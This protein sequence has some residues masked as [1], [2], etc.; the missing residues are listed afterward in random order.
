MWK[1]PSSEEA[2]PMTVSE[3]LPIV[4][5]ASLIADPLFVILYATYAELSTGLGAFAPTASPEN[6]GSEILV[7]VI[8]A[9]AEVASPQLNA[10]ARRY[11][12]KRRT[13]CFDIWS[14]RIRRI[15]TISWVMFGST[16]RQSFFKSYRAPLH[17][18]RW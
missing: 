13:N 7:M 15:Q 5:Q 3:K 11:L 9:K 16:S 8:C 18:R 4:A 12:G 17:E 2:V 14:F 6:F 1:R 10:I